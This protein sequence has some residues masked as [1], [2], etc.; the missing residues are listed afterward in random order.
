[1]CAMLTLALLLEEFYPNSMAGGTATSE[2]DN[3]VRIMKEM[4]EQN[5]NHSSIHAN[6]WSQTFLDSQER[7][8][9]YLE[10]LEGVGRSNLINNRT[11]LGQQL[12]MAYRM[13]KAAGMGLRSVN[14]DV[15]ALEMVSAH[16]CAYHIFLNVDEYLISSFFNREALINIS[17]D[18]PNCMHCLT[19]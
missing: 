5:Y 18:Y 3:L 13:I 8:E 10:I 2:A 15:I 17:P 4:N 9:E 7:S 16:V 1:M 19:K 11:R 14:R 6:L 12:D